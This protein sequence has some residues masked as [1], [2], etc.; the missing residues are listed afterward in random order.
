MGMRLQAQQQ[1]LLVWMHEVRAA[2][3]MLSLISVRF[4]S[5]ASVRVGPI[6]SPC[7]LPDYHVVHVMVG[8]RP[9]A[10]PCNAIVPDFSRRHVVCVRLQ[11]GIGKLV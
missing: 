1:L 10:L 11:H 4:E 8:L 9:K 2:A 6:D 5:H 7:G 3:L